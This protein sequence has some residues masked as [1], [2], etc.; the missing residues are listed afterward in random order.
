MKKILVLVMVLMLVGCQPKNQLTVVNNDEVLEQLNDIMYLIEQIEDRTQNVA[1]MYNRLSDIEE[2]LELY[3]QYQY[4][5]TT[6]DF[7]RIEVLNMLD[8]LLHNIVDDWTYDTNSKVICEVINGIEQ[9]CGSLYSLF[10]ELE[11]HKE[12]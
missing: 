3:R 2:E 10:E 1:G 12:D 5:E 11:K 8:Y 9:P 7:T 6:K 4:S